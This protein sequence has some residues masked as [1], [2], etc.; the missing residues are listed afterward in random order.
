MY[1][2]YEIHSDNKIY[3]GCTRRTMKARLAQHRALRHSSVALQYEV[4]VVF[5]TDSKDEAYAKEA[6]IIQLYDSTDPMRGYNRRLGSAKY[7]FPKYID[8]RNKTD[9][10][11]K[12]NSMYGHKQ[13]EETRDKIR[14]KTLARDPST[15]EKN[16]HKTPEQIA[17]LQEG[18]ARSQ[19]ENGHPMKGKTHSEDAR[20]KISESMKGNK[21]WLGRKHSDEAKRKISEARKKR[22]KPS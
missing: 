19:A 6:E 5:E 21:I 8:T 1:K 9:R 18:R 20:N 22:T 16:R 12:N 17:K 10:N 4:R 15:F 7:G 14:Q 11:G 2:V 3:V 13:S